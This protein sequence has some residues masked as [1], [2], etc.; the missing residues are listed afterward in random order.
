M[1]LTQEYIKIPKTEYLVLNKIYELNKKQ[2][3]LT[4]ICE[5]E[6]NINSWN[7]KTIEIDD[8]ID[9]I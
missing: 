2:Q 5:V 7:F 8:F 1:T 3:D 6:R 4:R 9:S